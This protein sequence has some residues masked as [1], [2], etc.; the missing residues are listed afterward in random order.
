MD[1]RLV[2]G[3]V[4]LGFTA[5]IMV[6]PSTEDPALEIIE[7]PDNNFTIGVISSTEFGDPYYRYLGDIAIQEI[8][9]YCV[10]TGLEY[11]FQ[12]SYACSNGQA[13]ET[14]D[15]TREFHEAGINLA[16]GYGWSSQYCAGLNGYGEENS[17]TLISIGSTSPVGC[18]RKIDHGF[19]LFP[20]DGLQAV[21]LATSLIDLNY[22]NLIII[23]RSDSWAEHII[24][25][26]EPV[27]TRMGGRI[28]NVVEY[29]GETVNESFKIYVKNLNTEYNSTD[30][31]DSTAILAISFSEIG[32]MLTEI[33]AYPE[34]LNLTWFGS[35]AIA[36]LDELPKDSGETA[37]KIKMI[38]PLVTITDS[39]KYAGLNTEFEAKFHTPLTLSL[40][41]VYDGIWLMALSV[42]ETGSDNATEISSVLPS[43]AESY[44]GLSGPIGFDE[45]GDRLPIDYEYWGVFED[46]GEYVN[47]VCGHYLHDT[48]A[49]EWSE[50]A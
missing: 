26:F 48:G 39:Q 4:V 13:Q 9:Q 22:T 49:I 16:V 47:K 38:S 41:N 29:P 6:S 11:R 8:N 2:F 17:M 35:D 5:I 36:N 34:L 27:Y 40:C 50:D 23:A 33:A 31:P 24:K 46:D 42:V 44:S 3:L 30:Y 12:T 45:F 1:K 15:K 32:G 18:C 25:D 21:P 43:I 14:Q 37:S 19:R 10:D 7:G 20:Y 28:Q